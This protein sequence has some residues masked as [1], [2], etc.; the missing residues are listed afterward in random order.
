MS[1]LFDDENSLD[2]DDSMSEASFLMDTESCLGDD[3]MAMDT[4]II[5]EERETLGCTPLSDAFNENSMDGRSDTP[6]SEIKQ[7]DIKQDCDTMKTDEVD[8]FSANVKHEGK[9]ASGYKC[10]V[11]EDR[12]MEEKLDKSLTGAAVKN[13]KTDVKMESKFTAQTGD[14]LADVKKEE[15]NQHDN[16]KEEDVP[17]SHDHDYIGTEEDYAE[18]DVVC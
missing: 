12:I 11:K 2:K 17:T 4:S 14:D 9:G 8:G 6:K 13:E 7:C 15:T 3:S 10:E 5:G 18:T 16:C 1:N